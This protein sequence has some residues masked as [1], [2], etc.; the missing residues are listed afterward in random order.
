M[1]CLTFDSKLVALVRKIRKRG[2]AFSKQGI[3]SFFF[4]LIVTAGDLWS[5]AISSCYYK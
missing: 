2:Q 4:K 5:V 1:H 3:D